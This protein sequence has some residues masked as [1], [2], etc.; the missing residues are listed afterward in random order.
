MES[1]LFQDLNKRLKPE[2]FSDLIAL[3]ALGRPGPLNSGLVDD[4]I[5]SR[6]GEKEPEYIHPKLKPILKET[7]GMILYQEQVMQIAS[8]L[9]GYSLG[10]ADLLRRGMGKKKKKLIAR[11]R[12][13]FVN[14]AEENGIS[15][16]EAH[17]IFDQ[18]EYFGGYGFN[19]SHSAAYALIAYQ[20]AYLKVKYPAEFMAA[21]LSSVM[22][23]LD[24]VGTY[25]DGAREMELDVLPP[26]VNQS[27]FEFSTTSANQIR[28]GLK[29][30]KNVGKKAIESIVSDRNNKP[31]KSLSDFLKRV[32]LS[33]I[34]TTMIEA[35]I[36]S[37]AFDRF[38]QSRSQMLI[39]YEELYERYNSLQ[40]GS[41]NGQTSFFDIV[42]DNKKFY[43][44]SVEYPDINKI[45]L[46]DK[47]KWEQEYLGV[48]I[49]GHPLDS[50]QAK[51]KNLTNFSSKQNDE[52]ENIDYLQ[53]NTAGLILEKKN[54]VTKRN[55][56]MA[57]LTIEDWSGKIKV[58]VFPDLYQNL[59]IPIEVGERI[60]INGYFKDGDSLIARDI[61]SLDIPYLLV[62]ID[63]ITIRKLS[64]IKY[65]LG[66]NSGPSPVFFWTNNHII[67]TGRSY[68]IEATNEELD[69]Q[70]GQLVGKNNISRL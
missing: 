65:L 68:W 21:L 34:N 11:E 57:F 3:L 54:H 51:I 6:H 64:R 33:H 28:F 40:R 15:Q 46:K 38:E 30:I 26:D 49:S 36:K 22:S 20:T 58:V 5:K 53:V 55:N 70:L 56:Q 19:K 67:L 60:F 66:A 27:E 24:K 31:Y 17:N 62:K 18:M 32:D 35:L 8:N 45:D 61:F 59:S 41:Q 16:K 50:Y 29:V 23:N 12:E 1:Y 63:D 43:N 37:G 10:D 69:L 42:N 13:K 7:F 25:I 44:D 47:L 39:K 2:N 4:F 52:V 48:Y 14:G 9:A